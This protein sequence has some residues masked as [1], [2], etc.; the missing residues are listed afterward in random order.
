[1]PERPEPPHPLLFIG[2]SITDA[3]R[4]SDADHL[5]FG[6]VRDVATALHQRGEHRRVVNTG[7]SGNRVPDL[8]HRFDEDALAHEP[9]VLTVY[10]GIN[11]VW[12]AFDAADPTSTEDFE[13]GYRELLQRAAEARIP[14]LI[15]VE[16]FAVPATDEQRD[17]W[18]ADLDPKRAVVRRLADETGAA[19]VPLQ[20][21]LGAVAAAEGVESV[22]ADGV[23]P[24]PH[25]AQLIAD[26]WLAVFDRL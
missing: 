6:W 20:E 21:S 23:H 24:S 9:S 13:Q 16:P 17:A 5:G 25:G 3:D 12:R 1:M 18:P 26:A 11:D 14:Q 19:F 15:L 4:R 8:L 7:I 22:A 10:I 2:D